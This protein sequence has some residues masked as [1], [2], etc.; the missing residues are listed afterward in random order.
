MRIINALRFLQQQN[1]W[2]AIERNNIIYTHT[3]THCSPSIVTVKH[4]N[5]LQQKR[6]IK[7]N[8]VMYETR[9]YKLNKEEKQGAV[10]DNIDVIFC[11]CYC[12]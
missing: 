12:Y 7:R 6:N 5:I 11:D 4:N 10:N 9:S 3:Q 2:L 8:V 1:Q